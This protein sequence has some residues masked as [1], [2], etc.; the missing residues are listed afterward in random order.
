[1][2][3]LNRTSNIAWQCLGS[4]ESNVNF[5]HVTIEGRK[6]FDFFNINLLIIIWFAHRFC[7]IIFTCI[8]GVFSF[9]LTNKQLLWKLFPSLFFTD[10]QDPTEWLGLWTFPVLQS[11]SLRPS[12]CA[13]WL[14]PRQMCAIGGMPQ[15]NMDSR[16]LSAYNL[17]GRN[18]CLLTCVFLGKHK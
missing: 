16:D 15:R 3:L 11:V 13:V 8:F 14:V 2:F 6:E 12:L 18:L 17:Q 5:Y 9:Y 10:H 4:L 7:K 1:M